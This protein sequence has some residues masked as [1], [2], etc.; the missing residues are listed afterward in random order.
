MSTANLYSIRFDQRNAQNTAYVEK[1][2]S[3]SNL[4]LITDSNG[5]VTGSSTVQSSSYSLTSSYSNNAGSSLTTGSTYPITSSFAVT[6]SYALSGVAFG[7]I[8][9]GNPSEI[10]SYN[11]N[12]DGGTP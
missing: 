4:V 2:V 10:Y 3:G 5:V 7:N 6:A 9:G 1:F 12:I 11:S 8:D